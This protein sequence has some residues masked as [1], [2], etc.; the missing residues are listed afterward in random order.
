MARLETHD[1]F[2]LS[3]E[4]RDEIA[5]MLWDVAIALEEGRLAD[6]LERL[7]QAREQLSQAMRDGASDEEIS[8][9]MQELQDAMRQ[10]MEQL[11]Q[12]GQEVIY[13]N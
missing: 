10:Y 1:Q 2:G 7:K 6:A 3:P 4:I 9:L 11:A 5:Q 13:S 8:E 12:E